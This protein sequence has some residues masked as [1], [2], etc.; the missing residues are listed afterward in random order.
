M[1]RR[2]LPDVAG[3]GFR[4]FLFILQIAVLEIMLTPACQ[5]QFYNNGINYCCELHRSRIHHLLSSLKASKY[6]VQL[7]NWLK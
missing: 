1:V 2:D 4:W 6:A 3:Q 5:F 7:S